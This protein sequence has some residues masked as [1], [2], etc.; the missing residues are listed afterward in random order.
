MSTTE[1]GVKDKMFSSSKI[2]N[3]GENIF[4][5]IKISKMIILQKKTFLL[6][7]LTKNT[8]FVKQFFF[9]QIPNGGYIEMHIFLPIF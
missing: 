2:E 7:F 1:I 4:F 9:L 8:T 5:L 6:Y 3:G